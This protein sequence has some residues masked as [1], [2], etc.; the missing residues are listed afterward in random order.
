MS[1]EWRLVMYVAVKR[2]FEFLVRFIYCEPNFIY[3]EPIE[4]YV[5]KKY[6]HW[7]GQYQRA[8]KLSV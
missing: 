7:C 2:I 3:C 8:K 6:S 4:E 1:S 5:A